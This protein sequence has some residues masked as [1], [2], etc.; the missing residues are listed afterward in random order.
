MAFKLSSELV[1][2]AKG[3]GDAIRKSS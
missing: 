3:S 2:A 1:D